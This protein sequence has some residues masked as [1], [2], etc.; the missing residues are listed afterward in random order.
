[1]S[2]PEPSISISGVGSFPVQSGGSLIFFQF[3]R[4]RKIA[5]NKFFPTFLRGRHVF[6]TWGVSGCPL[7]SYAPHTFI[8]PIHL[9]T[10]RGVHPHMFPILLCASVCSQ[11][12]LHAVG[13]VGSPLTCGTLPL[14]LSLNGMPPPQLHPPQSC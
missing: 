14:H 8:Y 13:V 9:Y 4:C 12:L 6:Y 7:H 10:P 2:C 1:M 5:L 11:R 3:F